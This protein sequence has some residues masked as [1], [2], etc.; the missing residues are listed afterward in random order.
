M[1]GL[2]AKIGW[3]RANWSRVVG[4]PL[5]NAEPWALRDVPIDRSTLESL[6]SYGFIERLGNETFEAT[7]FKQYSRQMSY[8][9]CGRDSVFELIDEY[10]SGSRDVAEEF[11]ARPE[12][13][14]YA[15][16]VFSGNSI[17]AD[18]VTRL[19]DELNVDIQLIGVD[20]EEPDGYPGRFV[21]ASRDEL[22]DVSS[23]LWRAIPNHPDLLCLS[24]AE[25]VSG[26]VP[27]VLDAAVADESTWFPV[28]PTRLDPW[29]E[30]LLVNPSQD[31]TNEPAREP[32]HQSFT[33]CSGV[34][35]D[36][37]NTWLKTQTTLDAFTSNTR[38]DG[39]ERVE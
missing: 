28:H 22:L 1:T 30:E 3:I 27:R 11:A 5:P 9:T 15:I 2:Q 7:R 12:A 18:D 38:T 23:D 26:F 13:D 35:Q 17:V 10:A 20:T 32:G 24:P 36:T 21:S 34:V 4:V 29:I 33:P 19:R 6:K 14:V 16:D 31:T 39:G 25:S 8:R 37:G